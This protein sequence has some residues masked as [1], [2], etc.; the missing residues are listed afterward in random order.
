[1]EK[2]VC[3]Q[4]KDHL[5]THGLQE[6]LQSAYRELHSTETALLRVRTNILKAMDDNKVVAVI[7]LDLSAAFDT[8][9]HAL[10]LNRLHHTYG[11][12]DTALTW[13]SSYLQNR[14]FR[15]CVG[16]AT[17]SIHKLHFG[18]PQGSV[19]GPLFFVLYIC[20]LGA[21][22]RKCGWRT[23]V[24]TFWPKGGKGGWTRCWNTLFVYIFKLANG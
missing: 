5:K 14:S 1:M 21:I 7:L 6:P 18:I 23:T 16:D 8:V 24:L 22:I 11:I 10:L 17:S 9:D 12:C 19:V 13:I 2:V 4:I 20:C 3:N 15:V